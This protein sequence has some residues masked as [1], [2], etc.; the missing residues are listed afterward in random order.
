MRPWQ[1][2]HP[3][4]DKWDEGLYEPRHADL[5]VGPTV[6]GCCDHCDLAR[7]VG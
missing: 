4:H 1:S 2:W 7:Q 6:G 3:G 5:V